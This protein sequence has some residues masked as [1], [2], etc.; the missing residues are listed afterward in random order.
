MSVPTHLGLDP[1]SSLKGLCEGCRGDVALAATL[2][3]QRRLGDASFW[4]PYLA[5]L[6]RLPALRF[7]FLSDAGLNQL[8]GEAHTIVTAAR[9]RLQQHVDQLLACSARPTPDE[10]RWAL[11]VVRSRAFR[12]GRLLPCA[13]TLNHNGASGSTVTYNSSTQ[14]FDV[15][16]TR[17][18][19]AGQEV[20][21]SYGTLRD[22]ELLAQYNFVEGSANPHAFL[23]LPR[24]WPASLLPADGGDNAAYDACDRAQGTAT[25]RHGDDVTSQQ[26]S[27]CNSTDAAQLRGLKEVTL[28]TLA[29]AEGP[30]SISVNGSLSAHLL[31]ALRVVALHSTRHFT[32]HAKV[33]LTALRE[34]SPLNEC[35]AKALLCSA[36]QGLQASYGSSLQRDMLQ[37]ETL[38]QSA[39]SESAHDERS[40]LLL[41]ALGLRIGEKKALARAIARVPACTTNYSEKHSHPVSGNQQRQGT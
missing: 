12:S 30:H 4:A 11:L 39:A 13:D 35:R 27:K 6:P 21:M 16:A 28:N 23:Q 18:Y 24:D 33:A 5:M 8:Q 14:R 3:H 38:Q 9:Q 29:A 1:T 10:A 32:R 2:L 7:P 15:H 19:S 25:G 37:Y 26:A 22:A 17:S 41:T 40:L 20:H 36:L 34:L 31:P